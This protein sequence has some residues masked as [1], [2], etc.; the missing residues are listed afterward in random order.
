MNNYN[1][2]ETNSTEK[3]YIEQRKKPKGEFDFTSINQKFLGE[4]KDIPSPEY[5]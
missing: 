5:F 2:I 4:M 3:K 1:L